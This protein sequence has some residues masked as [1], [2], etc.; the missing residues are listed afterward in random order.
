MASMELGER[1]GFGRYGILDEDSAGLL[2]HECG[3]RFGHLGLHVWR[4]HGVRAREY[5]EAHGLLLRR[6]LVVGQTREKLV[7]NATAAYPGKRAF[8][9]ARD[10]GAASRAATAA[11]GMSPAGLAASRPRV[12]QGRKGTVVEC[13]WCRALFCPLQ[14]ATQ[15]K[16]CSRRCAGRHTRASEGRGR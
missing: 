13:T 15:R 10:P 11:D 6:G 8:Q 12:G 2:C 3:E 5:R 9:L 4:R 1:D 16:H 14:G 7:A